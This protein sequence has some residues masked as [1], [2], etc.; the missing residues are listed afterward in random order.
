MI[1]DLEYHSLLNN[2]LDI[3]RIHYHLQIEYLADLYLDDLQWL[4]SFDPDMNID[5]GH[6]R[7]NLY[8]INGLRNLHML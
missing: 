5:M 8:E 3:D 4:N 6:Y 2:D 1:V 7:S